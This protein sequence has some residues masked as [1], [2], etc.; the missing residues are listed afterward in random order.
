M[1]PPLHFALYRLGISRPETQTSPAERDAIARHATGKT[2]AAEIGVWHGVTTRRIAEALAP[3][4]VVY[5]VDNYV[6][7]RFGISF[8]Y[9]V[10]RR[11][12]RTFRDRVK[13]VR[14]TA[15]EVAAEFA[16]SFAAKFQFVFIDGDHSYDGLRTD[17]EAW[18]PLIAPR[19]IVALHDSRS[20][21]TRDLA[22]TGSA[23]Y[24]RDVIQKDERFALL[25][26]VDTLTVLIRK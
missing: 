10:A 21:T 13:F 23:I 1:R 7:G 20:S 25:Q 12:T 8:P 9:A 22:T 3:N 5:A 17:W 15:K 18:T 19:G 24:T 11:N 16:E 6:T 14:A 4:G 2:L 26:E